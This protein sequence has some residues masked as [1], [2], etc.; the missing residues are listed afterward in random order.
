M[1]NYRLHL[2]GFLDS[3]D[4]FPTYFAQTLD[5]DSICRWWFFGSCE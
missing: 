3:E 5:D 2:K 1:A 4:D